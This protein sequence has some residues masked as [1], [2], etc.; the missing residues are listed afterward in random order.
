[1][2]GVDGVKGAVAK[3]GL[4]VR[5]PCRLLLVAV[6]GRRPGDARAVAISLCKKHRRGF[7]SKEY[8]SFLFVALY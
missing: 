4:A 1:M 8:Y 5:R 3:G 6:A 2:G 7:I